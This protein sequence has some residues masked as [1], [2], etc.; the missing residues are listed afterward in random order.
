MVKVLTVT[1]LHRSVR[2]YEELGDAV[3]SHQ[4]D[5]VALIG[6]FLHGFEDNNGRLTAAQCGRFLTKLPCPEVL[7]VRGNHEDSTWWDFADEWNKS[8]RKLHALHGEAFVHGPLVII[9]FPCLLGQEDAFIYPR[10]PLPADTDSWLPGLMRTHGAAARALWLMH[11]P[12]SGTPLSA[13][14]TVVE[15]NPEWT[16]AIA[17]FS[18]WLTIFG[19]DHRTPLLQNRWHCRLGQTTCVNVG[20]S[21]R[22]P[23][24]YALIELG[25]EQTAPSL[26]LQIKV[27]A[28]PE[29]ESV[30][31]PS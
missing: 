8:G 25:Y 30:I 27:T 16:E 14:G 22:D 15:G 2:L 20:Q 23:L 24:R 26:P 10:E 1:D 6:D 18:P 3:R 9:G 13:A 21:D 19:H 4:P 31:L 29:T 5:V 11:E 17:R 12:P 7:F 28:Y